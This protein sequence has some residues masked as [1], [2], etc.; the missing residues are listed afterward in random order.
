MVTP[1]VSETLQDNPDDTETTSEIVA[2][3]TNGACAASDVFARVQ[4]ARKHM[5]VPHKR[6]SGTES[7]IAA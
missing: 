6:F 2:G 7:Y 3:R 4:V 1:S 5:P